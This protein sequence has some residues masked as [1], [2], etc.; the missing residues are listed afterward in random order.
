MVLTAE[1]YPTRIRGVDNGFS[2]S[3]AWLFGFVLWPFL[4]VGLQQYTGAFAAAFLLIPA[5]MACMALG[6][7]RF[8]REHA[9]RELDQ[10]AT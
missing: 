10:I 5:A 9:G 1:L 6:V 4:A 2:W 7:W 3:V 8:R